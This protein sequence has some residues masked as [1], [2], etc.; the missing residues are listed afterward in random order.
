MAVA[1][2]LFQSR[3][4][5]RFGDELVHAC[6]FRFFFE[7]LLCKCRQTHDVRYLYACFLVHPANFHRSCGTVDFGHAVVQKDERVIPERQPWS[8]LLHA[9]I[10]AAEVNCALSIVQVVAAP[11]HGRDHFNLA[12]EE[13]NIKHL[14]I[15]YHHTP[16]RHQVGRQRA[17]HH[18]DVLGA[19]RVVH[20]QLRVIG[21]ELFVNSLHAPN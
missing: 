4:V 11:L 7:N 14:V 16:E 17:K 21:L 9:K 15:D 10:L 2:D 6:G 13:L 3:V 18:F 19:Y 8:L 5:N 1:H 20:G 12:T